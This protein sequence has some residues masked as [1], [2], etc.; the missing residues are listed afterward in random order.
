MTDRY[1]R[2][3]YNAALY[4]SLFGTTIAT[5][6]SGWALYGSMY[7]T[8]D[9][10]VLMIVAVVCTVLC[11]RFY[12]RPLLDPRDAVRQTLLTQLTLSQERCLFGVVAALVLMSAVNVLVLRQ[13]GPQLAVWLLFI[14]SAIA[15]FGWFLLSYHLF[16]A[17]GERTQ[18]F[19]SRTIAGACTDFFACCG[20]AY[21]LGRED[22]WSAYDDPTIGVGC[23]IFVGLVLY[24]L[25]SQVDIFG[26][27]WCETRMLLSAPRDGDV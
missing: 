14:Q 10:L 25:W 4:G 27:A 8:E 18:V 21:L 1:A 12:L 15:S 19:R 9:P 16:F 13:F 7:A 11:F 3:S 22:A 26:A 2:L 23:A 17:P 5:A 20:G 24:E 6:L